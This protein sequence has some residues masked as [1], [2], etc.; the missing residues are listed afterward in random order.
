MSSKD[1]IQKLYFK[2]YK[3]KRLI[4][5][6][7]CC[8]LFEGINIKD[9]ESVAMKFEKRQ[10]K[11]GVLESEAYCLFDL[12]GYGIPRIITYG[13]TLDYNILIE[14]LLGPSIYS[15]WTSNKKANEKQSLKDLC[16]LSIQAIDRLNYIH[17]KDIIHRDIKPANFLIGLKNPNVIY[18]IDFGFYRKYRSSRTGKHIKY[19]FIKQVIGSL[20]YISINGNKGFELSRRDDLES[21]G[22]LLVDLGIN[23]LPWASTANLSMDRKIQIEAVYKLKCSTKPDQLCKGLPEEFVEYI[24][25]VRKLKFEE[26][27]DY[28]YLKGLFISVLSRNEL[29]YDLLFS[30]II[31]KKR[32]SKQEQQ[33]EDISKEK[34]NVFMQRRP[35]NKKRLFATIKS[36]LEKDRKNNTNLSSNISSDENISNLNNVISKSQDIAYNNNKYNTAK[37]I[38][39]N[40]KIKEDKINLN[41]IFKLFKNN[42]NL[43]LNEYNINIINNEKFR[44]N[45][46]D[47]KDI[48]LDDIINKKRVSNTISSND[49]K[50]KNN[51]ENL[52]VV[53]NNNFIGNKYPQQGLKKLNK[54][55]FINN[56]SY[57]TMKEREKLKKKCVINVRKIANRKSPIPL[58]NIDSGTN[59]EIANI[60]FLNN[61]NLEFSS[62]Y[63]LT[64]PNIININLNRVVKPLY[65]VFNRNKKKNINNFLY[66]SSD[67][68]PLN[69]R[70]LLSKY[71]K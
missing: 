34:R 43:S 12:K 21:L 51:K 71:T 63:Q 25:Y 7:G 3:I 36:S 62:D 5:E 24:K 30:W 67:S 23:Y 59:N 53:H 18:L 17:S 20:N 31:N 68:G 2:K 15:L 39:N 14:E 1:I 69:N 40:E 66:P 33:K 57:M 26:E 22:Y 70:F 19:S 10:G 52:N 47:I 41:E 44:I 35:R 13:K 64:D 58:N 55:P 4:A 42:N 9:K 56:M 48:Y 54:K 8:K 28:N 60:S 50:R 49:L 32:V 11:V 61:N 6:S 37:I 45:V 65:K 38:P 27:P 29:K 16:M 46:N